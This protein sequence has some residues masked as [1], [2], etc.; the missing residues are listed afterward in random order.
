MTQ[1]TDLITEIIEEL[2]SS[3]ANGDQLK[4]MSQRRLSRWQLILM[5]DTHQEV[6]KIN[7]RLKKVEEAAADWKRY[8]SITWLLRHRTKGTIA[9]IATIFT[10]TTMLYVSGIRVPILEWL[11]LPPLTP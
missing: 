6:S 7:G 3:L 8:P 4:S 1:E 11:G 2:K 5:L 10:L 9:V